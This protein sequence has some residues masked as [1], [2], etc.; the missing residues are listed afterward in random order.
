[1][2][3]L[4]NELCSVVVDPE[5]G[6]TIESFTFGGEEL[7]HQDR[8]RKAS[9]R[10]YGIPIL[11]PTPNRVALDAYTFEGKRVPAVIHGFL[12]HRRCEVEAKSDTSLTGTFIF[13]GE[14]PLF[15]Y[16]GMISVTISLIGATL[17]W[18][19]HL[20]NT[21]SDA[22]AYGLALHP[23]FV[24]KRGMKLETNCFQRLI[25]DEEMLPTEEVVSDRPSSD[26]DTLA[27]DAIYRCSG[28]SSSTLRGDDVTVKIQGSSAFGYTVVYTSVELPFICIEP[29]SCAINAHNLG[30]QELAALQVLEGKEEHTHWIEITAEDRH[31][32]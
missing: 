4:S 19:F 22:F 28:P 9:G 23:F 16:L 6:L 7:L 25:T 27:I 2:I 1:M 13:D 8:E 31:E 17:R 11:F 15:P 5:M 26:V 24:K 20:V 3:T 18:E 30:N 12:R 10:T 29:Q 14:E 32:G 21:G